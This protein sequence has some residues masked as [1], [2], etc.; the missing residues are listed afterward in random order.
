M[1]L[2]FMAN[3]DWERAVYFT[4]FSDMYDIL[5]LEDYLYQEGLSQRFIPVV[6][7]R[8]TVY[9]EG[10][11][12]LLV[13]KAQWGSLN[14]YGVTVDPESD[15]ELTSVKLAYFYLTRALL[16]ER[17]NQEAI[18]VMDRYQEL[19]PDEKL[20]YGKEIFTYKNWPYGRLELYFVEFYRMAGAMDKADL[21]YAKT[22]KNITE[23]LNY[24]NSLEP[25]FKEYYKNDIAKLKAIL[26]D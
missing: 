2:D 4:S 3:N 6:P 14:K 22:M 16:D 5:G 15:R 9:L 10:S 18:N 7:S 11:Y 21:L 8:S 24:Y 12:D 26:D 20:P 23:E 25:K 19:F 1:L 13:N 17:K